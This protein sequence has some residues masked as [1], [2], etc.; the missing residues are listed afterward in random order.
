[1]TGLDQQQREQGPL[2]GW[3]KIQFRVTSPRPDESQHSELH[4]S[5]G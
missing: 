4:D 1:M 2:L 5:T 3:P